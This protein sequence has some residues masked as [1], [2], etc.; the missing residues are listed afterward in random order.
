MKISLAKIFITMLFYIETTF[1]E[2]IKIIRTLKGKKLKNGEDS[3]H[4]LQSVCYH[5]NTG[6]SSYCNTSFTTDETDNHSRCLC[7]CTCSK[8]CYSTVTY[9]E[10]KWRC[11]KNEEVRKQLGCEINATLFDD[12][13]EKS[14]LRTLAPVSNKKAGKTKLKNPNGSC[15]INVSSSWYIECLGK[16]VPLGLHTN[17]T[18]EMFLLKR[19]KNG[20]Y[21]IKVRVGLVCRWSVHIL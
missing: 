21:F 6:C 15:T 12:E 3:F 18:T 17:R 11:L 2:S 20:A 19:R 13:T 8:R 16:K 9:F 5:E 14:N 7:S 10:N 4:I 1:P